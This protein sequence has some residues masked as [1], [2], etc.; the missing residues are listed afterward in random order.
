[1]VCVVPKQY[2]PSLMY[3]FSFITKS[4]ANSMFIATQKLFFDVKLKGYVVLSFHN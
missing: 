4:Y 3:L 1:M 2:D